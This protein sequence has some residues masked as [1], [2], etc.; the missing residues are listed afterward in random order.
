MVQ[1]LKSTE[2][3]FSKFMSIFGGVLVCSEGDTPDNWLSPTSLIIF[4]FN[5]DLG[6]NGKCSSFPLIL[7]LT[8]PIPMSMWA[9]AMLK[10][11]LPRMRATLE[12]GCMS[13]TTKSTGMKSSPIL[14]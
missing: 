2:L 1:I 3:D 7:N 14:T 4:T 10:K 11:G 8:S 6:Q 9:F 5:A 12:S 13:S